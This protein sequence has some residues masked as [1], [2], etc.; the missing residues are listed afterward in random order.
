MSRAFLRPLFT[1]AGACAA[2]MITLAAACD[3]S[4]S[5][6]HDNPAQLDSSTPVTQ[7]SSVSNQDTGVTV[8]PD[9][10][11]VPNDSAP[12][13]VSD[14][15]TNPKT[16]FEIINACTDAQKIDKQP[17]LPLLLPDGGLPPPP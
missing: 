10:A 2:A 13:P 11:V 17:S 15:F 9:G 3:D 8:L 14:C 12:P 6:P 4:S 7:D 5:A 1:C 16:H